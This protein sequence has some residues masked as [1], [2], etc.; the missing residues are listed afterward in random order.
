LNQ[1]DAY[2]VLSVRQQ[3][4]VPSKLFFELT[5]T[6]QILLTQNIVVDAVIVFQNASP[7]QLN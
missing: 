2:G 7:M 6:T 5:A 1:T 4:H 3:K